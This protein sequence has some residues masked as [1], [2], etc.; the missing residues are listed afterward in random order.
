MTCQWT[1][2]HFVRK[3]VYCLFGAKSLPEPILMC[4]KWTTRKETRWIWY[5]FSNVLSRKS[6]RKYSWQ[7]VRHRVQGIL[8]NSSPASVACMR[9]WIGSA[10]VQIMAYI[11]F[12]T[13]PLSK[14]MLGYYQMHPYRN[15]VRWNFS[16]KSNS[17]IQENAFKIVFKLAFILSRRWVNTLRPRQNGRHFPDDI[18]KWIFFNENVWNSIKISLK[19]VPKVPID[20]IPALVQIMAW[21]RTGDKL[22]S[23]PMMAQFNDA[24]MRHSARID[25]LPSHITLRS[26]SSHCVP[27]EHVKWMSKGQCPAANQHSSLIQVTGF[28][29]RY[30]VPP[31]MWDNDPWGII[32]M[33]LLL[34]SRLSR[35]MYLL[36]SGK[37]LNSL[38]DISKWVR[39]YSIPPK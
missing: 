1:G 6:I 34:K 19:F 25:D 23:E 15:K 2:F 28:P 8:I 7:K 26:T 33:W 13:K 24:Y 29:P 4:I 20:N 12:G 10:L 37:S 36:R 3:T 22:L 38:Y 11:L 32:V 18:F 5:E 39:L 35:L 27:S 9:Q 21:R 30:T 31:D 14:L 17:F 16:Q